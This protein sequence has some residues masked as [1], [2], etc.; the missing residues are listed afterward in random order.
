MF[1]KQT[2]PACKP[3]AVSFMRHLRIFFILTFLF[4]LCSCG[5][6]KEAVEKNDNINI[7]SITQHIAVVP[8]RQLVD[9]KVKYLGDGMNDNFE[10]YEKASDKT[11]TKKEIHDSLMTIES[12]FVKSGCTGYEGNISINSDTLILK[13]ESNTNISCTEL[14]YYRVTYKISNPRHKKYI[15]VKE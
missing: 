10:E 14:E 3:L 9:A 13:L 1:Q 7:D 15:I 12:Y 11:F 2:T 8:H 5:D 6:K 4:S